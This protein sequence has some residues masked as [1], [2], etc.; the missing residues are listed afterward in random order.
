VE[1]GFLS[2]TL[3]HLPFLG[4]NPL[5][6]FHFSVGLQPLLD[7]HPRLGFPQLRGSYPRLYSILLQV[8]SDDFILF[9]ISKAL[10]ESEQI[11]F[12]KTQL[13][14][15]SPLFLPFLNRLLYTDL[16]HLSTSP[17]GPTSCRNLGTF[18][19]KRLSVLAIAS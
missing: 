3:F 2:D 17:Q 11:T 12:F 18:K 9:V 15:Y 4:F 14:F 10:F 19:T 16:R 5:L 8:L 7:L 6:G 13:T 1:V